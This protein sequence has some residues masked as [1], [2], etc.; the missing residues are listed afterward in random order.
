[1]LGAARAAARA[2]AG[3]ATILPP[4]N[5]YAIGTRPHVRRL[6]RASAYDDSCEAIEI[7]PDSGGVWCCA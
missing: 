3:T 6:H 1:M 4:A 7:L 5:P 2:A